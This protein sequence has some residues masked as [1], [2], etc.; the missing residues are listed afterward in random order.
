MQLAHDAGNVGSFAIFLQSLV[1]DVYGASL[2]A[3]RVYARHSQ[4]RLELTEYR[5][6][7]DLEAFARLDRS[8]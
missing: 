8:R 1:N 6:C 5:T 2:S 7:H 3:K 4:A